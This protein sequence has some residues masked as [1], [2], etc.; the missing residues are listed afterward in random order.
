M[1]GNYHYLEDTVDAC[2]SVGIGGI[3]SDMPGYGKS[4]ARRIID[5][6]PQEDIA[7]GIIA[8]LADMRHDAAI[9]VGHDWGAGVV[10]RS[11]IGLLALDGGSL[12]TQTCCSKYNDVSNLGLDHVH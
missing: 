9:W 5:E 3:A 7:E 8:R 11:N 4:T 6:Y 10:S 1:A 2:A 12:K